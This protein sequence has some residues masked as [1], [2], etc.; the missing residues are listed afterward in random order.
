[1][2]DCAGF[3]RWLD[4]G[5][6]PDGAVEARAHAD[7]CAR[8]AAALAMARE[9]DDALARAAVRA[10]AGFAARVM[11][12][13]A[14]ARIERLASLLATDTLPWWVRAAAEPA[15]AIS[16]ALAAL[17]LWQREALVRV[18]ASVLQALGHPAV[19]G[20]LRRL[21]EPRLTLDL[22]ALSNVPL[23]LGVLFATAPL[24]WM[25]GLAAYHWSG[26]PR[27]TRA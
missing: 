22:S 19:E 24:A 6:P 17:V 3:E 4:E 5:T 2:T 18:S 1:M 13:V 25:V 10:P 15:A 8:C 20:A 21:G 11:E 14:R 12:R 23:L 9:L 26:D 7:A 16:L 27:A